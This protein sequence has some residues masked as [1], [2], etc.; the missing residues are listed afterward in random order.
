M[1]NAPE[2]EGIAPIPM[3]PSYPGFFENRSLPRRSLGGQQ[4]QEAEL[5][6]SSEDT[7]GKKVHHY[8]NILLHQMSKGQAAHLGG[9]GAGSIMEVGEPQALPLPVGSKGSSV[10]SV[11]LRLAPTPPS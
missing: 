9:P 11:P 2:G 5:R 10:R 6:R 7:R 1:D 3:V 4:D 8:D